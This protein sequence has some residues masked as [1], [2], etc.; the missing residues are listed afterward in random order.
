MDALARH[1]KQE[2]GEE[3]KPSNNNSPSS[4][5]S[6]TTIKPKKPLK[7]ASSSADMMSS[8]NKR[9]KIRKTLNGADWSSGDESEDSLL[10]STKI[11]P[12]PSSKPLVPGSSYTQYR[13][14]KAQ[15]LYLIREN[16]MLQDEYDSTQKKLRRMKT[17]RKVLLDAVMAAE[18]KS[19]DEG[20][21]IPN[22][23][24]QISL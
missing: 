12:N 9:L 14:A 1:K 18:L 2:H 17:E 16:E 4:S 11:T 13:I 19:E 21:P 5:T 6:F 22:I 7:R 3:T 20:D 24:E 23:E 10:T 15:L 8:K